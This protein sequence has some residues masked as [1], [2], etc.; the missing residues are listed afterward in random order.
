[1]TEN[2]LN[3]LYEIKHLCCDK[4]KVCANACYVC[5]SQCVESKVLDLVNE[6]INETI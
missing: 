3:K 4:I 6:V 2:Q 1:M 5:T